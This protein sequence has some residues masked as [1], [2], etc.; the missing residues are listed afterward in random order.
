M[1]V[2]ELET[3]IGKVKSAAVFVGPNGTGPWEQME[4]RALL[5]TFVKGGVR[6]I[7]VVLPAEHEPNWSGF[8]QDFHRVDFRITEPNP[9]QQFCRGI[10]GQ[11]PD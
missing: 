7:P 5:R 11:R 1:W 8:M 3:I 6:V 2:D 9:M 10:T 4:I